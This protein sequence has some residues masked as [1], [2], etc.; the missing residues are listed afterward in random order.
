MNAR[1]L[2][3]LSALALSLS[4]SSP[5][6]PDAPPA[7]AATPVDE[8]SF[9]EPQRVRVT[10][11][12]LDLELDFDARRASG[13]A[14]LALERSDRSAPLVLDT[15]GLEIQRVLGGD[16]GERRF[17]LGQGRAGFGAPLSIALEAADEQVSVHYRTAPDAAA[18]QWLAPEQTAGGAQPFLF[19]QGQAV[20]TRTWIPLQDS[21]GV[22]VTYEARVRAPRDLTVVMSAEQQGR[23]AAGAWRFRMPQAIPPYLIALA[24]GALEFRPISERCG[25]W[26]EAPVV[27]D[28][29]REFADVEAML[30]AA[31]R[32]FGPYR[33]GRYD[34]LI[35]P[36]SFPYGGMENPRLTF[37]TPTI[38][39]GDR[40]LVALVAHELAHSWSGNLVTNATWRDFWLNEGFTVYIENRLMEEVYGPERA[41]MEQVLARAELEAEMAGMAPL[42]T[43]LHIDL[44]RRHPDEG[45]SGVPYEKG[46]LFLRRLEEL[47]G[48]TAFDA[49]LRGW[50]DA[51]AFRSVTT[52]EFLAWLDARLLAPA[53]ELAAQLDVGLWMDA[54]GMPG[55]APAASSDALARV[56]AAIADWRAG[57]APAQLDT[58]GWVTQQWQHFLA[59][60]PDDVDEGDMAQLDAAFGFTQSGNSEILCA[61]LEL[62]IQK[63]YAPADAV[64]EEFLMEVGRRKY[65][66]PLYTALNATPQG[67]ER[68]LALYGRARPRYHSVSTKTLDELLDWKG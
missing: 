35:L 21:P 65:L 38:L 33:W 4:C 49:F 60:L 41:Q 22:R 51:H 17:E 39:A 67:R 32:L 55:D 31:E 29:A 56:E 40:S 66:K 52:D 6:A 50:F 18:M 2:P 36:P 20:L 3:A 68:A 28:A 23:D 9:S 37:L 59:V 10:H 48:R 45:F 44:A 7:G 15:Q 12:A 11:V 19:T 30:A 53:P 46:A 43:V 62:A 13:S 61:W 64:L 42:D 16:G 8:H 27:E 24:C 14:T 47:F 63:G 54:P 5:E 57:R 58:G 34:L 26:A 1:I 25:A